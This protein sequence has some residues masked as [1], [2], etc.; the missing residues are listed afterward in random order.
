MFLK[1]EKVTLGPMEPEAWKSLALAHLDKDFDLL[2]SDDPFPK[3]A[4]DIARIY[5]KFSYPAGRIFQ[6][7]ASIGEESSTRGIGMVALN[8]IDWKNRNAQGHI[9]IWDKEARNKGFGNEAMKLMVDY[10][11]NDL[12]LHRIY[13]IIIAG[14]DLVINTAKSVGFKVEAQMTG[15]FFVGGRYKNGVLVS[16]INPVK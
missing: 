9:S 12:G 10:G 6:I 11:F 14:N 15:C 4:E 8:D 7:F 2:T 16:I 13:S 3:S 5:S 1:G